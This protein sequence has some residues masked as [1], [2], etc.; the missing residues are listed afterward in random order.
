[1]NALFEPL[2]YIADSTQRI[3]WL[4]LFSALTLA[5]LLFRLKAG[6]SASLRN[7]GRFML[8]DEARRDPSIRVDITYF[9]VT[10][11][12][13][14][15]LIAPFLLF[16]HLQITDSIQAWLNVP[17]M[18]K[19]IFFPE[20]SLTL[21]LV[22]VIAM[23]FG[24][25][26][27]HWLQHKVPFLWEFHKVH[28]SATS[29][30]PL[31]VYRMHPVD[32]ILSFSL[33]SICS[34]FATLTVSLLLGEPAP[35]VQVFGLNLV[36]FLFY[37]L[38]YN[39]RHSHVWLP[40][41]AW[42]SHLLISPAQHQIH[43]SDAPR[44]F[45]KNFGLIL[46]VWDWLF[47]TLYI[48][49]QQ[50]ELQYGI[51]PESREYSSTLKLL[52]LPFLK[53]WRPRPALSLVGVSALAGMTGFSLLQ[54]WPASPPA[55]TVMMEDMTWKEVEQKLQ[56]GFT[57]V[58]IPTGG[59]EQNGEHMILGKH[60]YI[61]RQA[62]EDIARDLGNAMVAPV[63][64]YVPEQ[65]HEGWPGTISINDDS[66][67]L[68]LQEIA[69]NMLSQGFTEI[70]FIGDSRGN[71]SPQSEVAMKL[72]QHYGPGIIVG[73]LSHYYSVAPQLKKLAAQGYQSNQIGSHAGIR[74]T[75]E[76]LYIH[77]EGVRSKMLQPGT[78][79]EGANGD[80]WLSSAALGQSLNRDKVRRAV[81]Q[82]MGYRQLRRAEVD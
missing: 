47:S 9:I 42:L 57:T 71:Q 34:N 78:E 20:R 59:T 14:I 1:M 11:L 56:Q 16:L 27:A 79:S 63:L 73:N 44:H 70:Y 17:T 3:Y 55:D 19:D 30:T 74:D 61:I 35:V 12:L 68:L 2:G 54:Q 50:E 5:L 76:L 24:V 66:Y 53:N 51:G 43:H 39:L 46:A 28:H 26:L 29:L 41:P 32:D 6:R 69:E 7:F 80:F 49:R 23:D 67:S 48:P 13:M 72:R 31:T 15:V 22:A 40:Y 58:L 33:A 36:V 45:D 4:Y 25:F 10:K 75:S 37:L 52:F 82:V 64:P 60:N 8:P 38:G 18:P 21:T 77:P 62:S 65:P 81:E